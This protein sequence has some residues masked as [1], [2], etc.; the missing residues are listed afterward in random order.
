[1][2]ASAHTKPAEDWHAEDIKA[3]VR[4]TGTTFTAMAEKHGYHRTVFSI[5]LAHPYPA[6][7][8]LIADQIGIPPETIWPSR[9]SVRRVHPN[10]SISGKSLIVTVKS[11]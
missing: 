5:A 6:V 8:R 3:A 2:A 9:Y 11:V 1:M 10:R 7:E 4:K